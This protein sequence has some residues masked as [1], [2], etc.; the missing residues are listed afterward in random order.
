MKRDMDFVRDILTLVSEKGMYAKISYEDFAERTNEDFIY[1]IEILE[2]ANLVK[3]SLTQQGVYVGPHLTWAG[4]D[5]LEAAKDD[6]RW[7]QAKKIASDLGGTTFQV[8]QTILTD[9]IKQ[10]VRNLMGLP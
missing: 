6:T 9:L 4:N 1:H 10:Q 5:F 7:Q 8:F 3:G 2:E